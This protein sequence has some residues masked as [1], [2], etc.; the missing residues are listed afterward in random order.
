MFRVRVELSPPEM[1]IATTT[2][3]NEVRNHTW[4]AV[5]TAKRIYGKVTVRNAF[6][7]GAPRA[8]APISWFMS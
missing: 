4:A 8:R 6:Q 5:I 2:S 1:N 3:S 7:H